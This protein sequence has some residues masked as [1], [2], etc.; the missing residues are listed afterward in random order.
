L[1]EA[2][3]L[4]EAGYRQ[5]ADMESTH[6]T[7]QRQMAKGLQERLSLGQGSGEAGRMT[8]TTRYIFDYK[9]HLD[10]LV[11]QLLLVRSA[12]HADKLY[13]KVGSCLHAKVVGNL[14]PQL[15]PS[16]QVSV[17]DVVGLVFTGF[18]R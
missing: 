6:E 16:E 7:R 1:P 17:V 9:L 12:H 2:T 18:V 8:R 10:N 5:T 14:G 4:S 11:P 15:L 13:V 3:S